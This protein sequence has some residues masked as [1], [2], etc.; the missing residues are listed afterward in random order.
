MQKQYEIAAAGEETLSVGTWVEIFEAYGEAEGEKAIRVKSMR[1][2]GKVLIFGGGSE[3]RSRLLRPHEGEVIFIDR[4]PSVTRFGL[5]L[6][7]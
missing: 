1:V 2:A 3:C 6:R 7:A 5:R 4:Q